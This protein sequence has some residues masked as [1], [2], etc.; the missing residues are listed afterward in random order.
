MMRLAT[1]GLISF[2]EAPADLGLRGGPHVLCR[3]QHRGEVPPRGGT[4]GHALARTR[5][6][7]RAGSL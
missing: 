3:G 2:R 1:T 4:A 7:S 5:S 6:P